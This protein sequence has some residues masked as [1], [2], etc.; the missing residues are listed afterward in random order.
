METVNQ[1]NLLQGSFFNYKYLN[2]DYLFNKGI[3]FFKHFFDIIFSPAAKATW[4]TILFFFAVF[5]ISIIAYTI[6]RMFEIRHKEHAHLKHEI[7]EYAHH[8][9][10]Y[11]KHL[12]EQ[13]GGSKNE[14]WGK[15]LNY[16]FSQYSSDW[17][18]AIIEAD[19]MLDRLLDQLG[20]QGDSLG[21]KLKTTTQETFPLLTDAWQVHTI[22]NRI[23]HEGLSFE[24]SHHEAKRVIGIYE[25]IFYKYGYI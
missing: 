23:A 17:K 3:I 22:R 5:F 21:D 11:A 12:H 14:H 6:V 7:A 16:L 24:L 1:N 10:E 9:A 2:P 25:H 15:T 4:E 8:Q 18:L 13:V 19:T 20:F